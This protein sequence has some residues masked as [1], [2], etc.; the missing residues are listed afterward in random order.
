MKT[1]W[2]YR[3]RRIH[4]YL[5]ILLG[6]QFFMWT[7]G[8]SYKKRQSRKIFVEFRFTHV[9]KVRSTEM[10]VNISVLRTFGTF[11]SRFST[12]IAVLRTCETF[13]RK[14]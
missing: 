10:L 11:F 13:I 1:N 12:N 2:N 8:F 7:V 5:G 14:P 4:R 3:I 9:P 6:I